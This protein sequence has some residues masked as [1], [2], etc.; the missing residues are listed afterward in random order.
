M[1]ELTP[2]FTI[3]VWLDGD[4]DPKFATVLVRDRLTNSLERLLN[5]GEIVAYEMVNT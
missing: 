4:D 1:S 5:D 2:V 3:Q